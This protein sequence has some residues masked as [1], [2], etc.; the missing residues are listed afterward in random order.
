MKN[1]STTP[2]KTAESPDGRPDR[3][4]PAE[5][6]DGS[7]HR[8][9]PRSREPWPRW[10]SVL[11]SPNPPGAS[12]VEEQQ[13]CNFSLYSRHAER[14]RLLLFGEDD[15]ARPVVVHDID[16]RR[17]KTWDLWHCRLGEAD[18]RGARY[19]AYSV[20]GPRCRPGPPRVRPGQGPPRPLREG[21]LLPAVVRPRGGPA[22]GP[23]RRDGPPGRP[24]PPRAGVRLGGRP[25]PAPRLGHGHLRDARAR[26]HAE[27]DE[28]ASRPRRGAPTPAWPRRFPTCKSLGVTDGRAAPGAA[29]RPPG[30]ELLGLHAAELLRPPPVLR[31]RPGRPAPRVPG[32][33][34][35]PARGGDRGHPRR[36]LQP[37]GR[38]GPHGAD[39]QLPGDRQRAPT[40]CS[41]DPGR[42]YRDYSG[43]GN[44]LACHASA[45]RAADPR[46]PAATGSPRCTSTASGSTWPRCSPATPTG[47]FGGRR[48]AADRDPGRP[49]PA[50]GPPDRR[51]VGRGRRLPARA[52]FPGPLWQQWNGRFRDDVRRFVRGDR[53]RCRR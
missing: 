53:S 48:P 40:T 35:G 23:Q 42:P 29:V 38:G 8:A 14:V 33:G 2:E 11:G 49:G 15:L 16:P 50:R 41:D 6:R 13:A 19:Y 43:C 20:D 31:R 9:G 22:S 1:W 39:L 52:R 21:G 46:Q 4:A 18:L 25:A 51:A 44:T 24:A 27:P 26:L 5:G 10:T 7:V 3:L 17:N 32:D 37:H 34:Q 28:R 45:V 36:R 47:R 30:G 12:W